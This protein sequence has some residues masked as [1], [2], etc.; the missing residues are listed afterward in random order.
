LTWYFNYHFE[1]IAP[2]CF[3][4]EKFTEESTRRMARELGKFYAPFEVLDSRSFDGL[5]KLISDGTIGYGVH[6]FVHHASKFTDVYYYKFSF[7]GRFSQFL[8][9][10]NHPYGVSHGDDIQY[11]FGA[12][13]VGASLIQIPDPEDVTVE[14]MTRIWVQFAKTG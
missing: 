4:F 12:S 2:L 3:S 14:R 1:E 9:P 11:V 10:R 6:N 13:F 8:Y 5:S 7:I